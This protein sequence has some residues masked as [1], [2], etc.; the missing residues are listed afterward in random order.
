MTVQTETIISYIFLFKDPACL[1]IST[2]FH[3][4]LSDPFCSTQLKTA[5]EVKET[6]THEVEETTHGQNNNTSKSFLGILSVVVFVLVVIF[7]I[8]IFVLKRKYWGN[9]GKFLINVGRYRYFLKKQIQQQKLK[10]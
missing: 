9:T 10:S 5:N 6:T 3:C 7:V 4:Y 2:E 8:G 1:N